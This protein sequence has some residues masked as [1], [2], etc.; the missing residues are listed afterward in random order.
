MKIK[1]LIISFALIIMSLPKESNAAQSEI[2]EKIAQAYG[3]DGFDKITELRY[4]FNAKVGGMEI[5]R[6]WVWQPN[7]NKVTLVKVGED[8]K[9]VSYH[10]QD[11]D[12]DPESLKEMDS[13]FINDQYWLVFPFHLVW[14]EGI[15]IE[16][17]GE[18]ENLPIGSGM[19][20]KVIVSYPDTGGYTP[21]DVYE[22]YI[23]ENY[24]ILEWVYRKGGDKKP[25]RVSTWEDNK[26][27]GPIIISLDHNGPEGKFRVWFTDVE[28]IT[29]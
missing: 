14:D 6:S 8:L 23:D 21:G 26:Q 28:V 7:E 22:L 25:T 3:I 27:F 13:W 5:K 29:D 19:T 17:G 11:L 10:R 2:S 24:M 18:S 15:R 9:N 12:K 4:T 16:V 20:T 1:L